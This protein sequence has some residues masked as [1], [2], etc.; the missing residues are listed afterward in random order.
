LT[1]DAT[2]L[3]RLFIGWNRLRT[4]TERERLKYQCA[5]PAVLI[6]PGL[7]S[8]SPKNGN[9]STTRGDYRLFRFENAQN[10]SL[11]TSGQFAKARHWRAFL[12]APETFSESAALRGWRSS[13]IRTRLHPNSLLTGNL[14]GNFSVFGPIS[15]A[16]GQEETVLQWFFSKFPKMV[17]G[18]Y[19]CGTGK[20]QP[21]TGNF[22]SDFAI[23]GGF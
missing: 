22:G 20:R 14:T 21:G 18:N 23:F 7:W 11:E 6:E 3:Q 5:G 12:R 1:G 2:F 13:R 9:I 16:E 4:Q 8:L 17:S 19:F 10:R 15:Q